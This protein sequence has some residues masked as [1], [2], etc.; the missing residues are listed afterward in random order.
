VIRQLE[1][2]ET[3]GPVLNAFLI[4][5]L[6]DL[7]ANQAIGL[8]RQAFSQKRVDLRIAGDV[9]EVEIEMGLR[10]ARSTPPPRL[11]L[12]DP[13]PQLE[14]FADHG[15]DDRVLRIAPSRR[16]AKVGRNDPCP[17]GSGKKFKKCCLN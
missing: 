6:I 1:K 4:S 14:G 7:A 9:E 8:I 15:A 17:C 13:S 11:N 5:S 2:F 10:A 12:F 16:A 3:N